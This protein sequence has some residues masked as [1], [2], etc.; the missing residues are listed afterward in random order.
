ME[1]SFLYP[2]FASIIAAIVTT[3]GLLVIQRYKE[4]AERNTIYFISFASGVL[5]S[6]SILHIIPTASSMSVHAPVLTLSGFMLF[7]LINRFIHGYVCHKTDCIND[8][9]NYDFAI[10]PVIGIGLHSFLDGIVY[11]ITFSVSFFTGVL[12]VIGLILHEFHNIT[13]KDI[14]RALYYRIREHFL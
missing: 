5:I 14:Q 6:V 1:T 9:E 8:N 13:V 10:T 3:V 4:W 12:A 2:F 11:C 7:H